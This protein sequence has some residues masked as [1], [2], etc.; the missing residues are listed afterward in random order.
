MLSVVVI[1]LNG[2]F[3]DTAIIPEVRNIVLEKSFQF[4][5]RLLCDSCIW[6]FRLAP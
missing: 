2:L 1:Q 4:W 3:C 5:S 6:N